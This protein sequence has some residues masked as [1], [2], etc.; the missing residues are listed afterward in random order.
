MPDIAITT[1]FLVG[2]CGESE[3]EFD[4]TL[5]ALVELRFDNAFMFAYSERKGT[6]AA[7]TQPD[8]VPA[9]VKQRRLA[10]IIEVQRAITAQ[11]YAAQVGRRERVLCESVS[12]RSQGELL[13]RTDGYRP[14]IVGT[15]GGV[16]VGDLIEV[17]IHKAGPGTLYGRLSGQ[18]NETT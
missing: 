2:F 1:D 7:R 15:A 8:D 9:E 13:G 6:R 16:S 4:E 12:K 18:Q 17:E 5:A 14:V 10:H 3:A 11:S